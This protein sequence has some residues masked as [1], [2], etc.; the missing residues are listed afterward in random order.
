[1]S[2]PENQPSPETAD[3]NEGL[4]RA[5]RYE[6]YSA[7][8][9]QWLEHPEDPGLQARVATAKNQLETGDEPPAVPGQTKAD[10][11]FLEQLSARLPDQEPALAGQSEAEALYRQYNSI[12]TK[13]ADVLAH[14]YRALD[15]FQSWHNPLLAENNIRK[16]NGLIE[17]LEKFPDKFREKIFALFEINNPLLMDTTLAATKFLSKRSTEVKAV[18]HQ[19]MLKLA[20]ILEEY[21]KNLLGYEAMREPQQH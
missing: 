16:V 9:D 20:F 8:L 3:R 12:L 4:S 5:D 1:M 13:A 10:Q 6:A 18:A 15:H 21:E 11:D 2:N 19:D 17:T 14:S 7:L